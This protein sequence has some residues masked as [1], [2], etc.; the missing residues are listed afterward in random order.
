VYATGRGAYALSQRARRG[1]EWFL[2]KFFFPSIGGRGGGGKEA[3]AA[4]RGRGPGRAKEKGGGE[5]GRTL[6]ATGAAGAAASALH[7]RCDCE[8]DCGAASSPSPCSL[9]AVNL[10]VDLRLLLMKTGAG[11]ADLY[12]HQQH[13]H[14]R[15]FQRT[16]VCVC[17]WSVDFA[18]CCWSWELLCVRS[19]VWGRWPFDICELWWQCG[20]E[21]NYLRQNE[22]GNVSMCR[23]E[24]WKSNTIHLEQ[25]KKERVDASFSSKFIK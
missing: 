8:R 5:C 9:S 23:S 15:G 12:P 24:L 13:E 6:H 1:G 19:E 4:G 16:T 14:D 3:E 22:P 25:K 2:K 20:T 18:L 7:C 17:V 11:R 21:L 10:A